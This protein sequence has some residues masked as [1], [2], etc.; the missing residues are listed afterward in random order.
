MEEIKI[1][2]KEWLWRLGKNAQMFEVMGDKQRG[3][4]KKT[5]KEVVDKVVLVP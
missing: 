4:P 1:V 3:R 2:W 5:L